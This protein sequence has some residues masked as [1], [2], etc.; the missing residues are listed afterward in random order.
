MNGVAEALLQDLLAQSITQ[1]QLLQ[2]LA[3][4][5]T[6]AS[7]GGGGGSSGGSSSGGFGSLINP[8][9]LLS[10]A[11]GLV[12]GAFKILGGIVS[13]A[14]GIFKNLL[15]T[16]GSV[17]NAFATLGK[18]AVEAGIKLS[19]FYNMFS[20]LPLLGPFFQLRATIRQVT[21]A[22][23]E[24]YRNTS[25]VGAT[26]GGSI[27]AARAAA[28]QAELS[29]NEYGKVIRESAPSLA[30]FGGTVEEGA[31]A[32]SRMNSQFM[33]GTNEAGVSVLGLGYKFDEAASM[34]AAFMGRQAAIGDARNMSDQQIIKGAREYAIS[35]DMLS[36]LTGEERNAL[37]KK[38]ELQQEEEGFI[39]FL[40]TLEQGERER[41][42]AARDFVQATNP[43]SIRQFMAGVQGLSIPMD[44]YG[45]Q[46]ILTG[47]AHE[48]EAQLYQDIFQK[49]KTREEAQRAVYEMQVRQGRQV[50][51][52]YGE[53]SQTFFLSGQ[54]I[55]GSNVA[56]AR[57]A[58][59][60][61]GAVKAFDQAMREVGK[62]ANGNAAT[63]AKN[64]LAARTMGER[65][66]AVANQILNYFSPALATVEKWIM[67]DG[68]PLFQELA[69]YMGKF[70]SWLIETLDEYLTIFKEGG[71]EA[72][73]KQVV[74]DIKNGLK[75]AWNFIEGPVMS[76]YNNTM[77]PW[78]NNLY[79]IMERKLSEL[80]I[81]ILYKVD[82]YVDEKVFG[83]NEKDEKERSAKR[84]Y[85]LA[86]IGFMGETDP[87]KKAELYAQSLSAYRN[88]IA[89]L[90]QA[91]GYSITA[92]GNKIYGRQRQMD[93]LQQEFQA[94][95]SSTG[96]GG[97]RRRHSGTIG[98]TGSWWEKES[99]P[100]SVQAGETVLTQSQLSQ[101][102]DTAGSN[103][104]AEQVERLNT[105]SAEMLVYL[106]ETAKNTADNM[107]ATR[108][109]NGNA[110]A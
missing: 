25:S 22:M 42:L 45:Q 43:A 17:A 7:G 94:F 87:V 85:E 35:L 77:K 83:I 93:A 16:V 58:D 81:N 32:L 27:D 4:G 99:G 105:I 107:R 54:K 97:E 66:L 60:A 102:V 46:M 5:F 34:L 6:G 90:Q 40:N 72:L 44:E 23:L 52:V 71:L 47:Q 76:F 62:T 12:T 96:N 68:I 67:K 100:L 19:D 82:R 95:L 51:K 50:G 91:G 61:G 15:S 39:A 21:E 56:L 59:E 28:R 109:L 79:T 64:E 57:R 92:E 9:N 73:F 108:A 63:E 49:T 75:A 41:L 104:L 48:L 2:K 13:T 33:R 11:V 101:I 38:L 31:R 74:T 18:Q 89:A 88:Y 3:R 36:R 78:L 86:K 110:L 80:M 14:W 30:A 69:K 65:L 84:D 103:K 8:L 70:V 55:V 106:R 37:A 29:F 26:F 24:L 53:M 20:G 98:M 1:T 10:G